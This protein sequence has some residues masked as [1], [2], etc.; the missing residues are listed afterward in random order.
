MLLAGNALASPRDSAWLANRPGLWRPHGLDDIKAQALALSRPGRLVLVTCTIGGD[1]LRR[2]AI[3][4]DLCPTEGRRCAAI[5]VCRSAF[6]PQNVTDNNL[7]FRYKLLALQSAVYA[8]EAVVPDVDV[9]WVDGN[10]VSWAGCAPYHDPLAGLHR[11]LQRVR[12]ASN[13]SIVFSSE[14]SPSECI[15]MNES[16]KGPQ[17]R[18]RCPVPKL[19]QWAAAL[20]PARLPPHIP[21][22]PI[23]LNS[24]VIAGRVRDLAPMLRWVQGRPWRWNGA[25]SDQ[26]LFYAWWLSHPVEVTLDYCSLLTHS[27]YRADHSL[28][29]RSADGTRLL[30]AAEDTCT[31][32]NQG[33]YGRCPESC[34]A[35]WWAKQPLLDQGP[36]EAISRARTTRASALGSIFCFAVT[37]LS[38][39]EWP[40]LPSFSR[41]LASCDESALY[42][43]VTLAV[44]VAIERAISGS[45]AVGRVGR[46]TWALNTPLF[47]QVWRHILSTGRHRGVQFTVKLDCDSIFWGARLRSVLAWYSG[48][49]RA[50]AATSP[51]AMLLTSFGPA[52]K[53]VQGGAYALS[54]AA[55]E[56]YARRRHECE[57]NSH[58]EAEDGYMSTCAGR[59]R[60]PVVAAPGLMVT[61]GGYPEHDMSKH[62]GQMF[63]CNGNGDGPAVIHPFKASHP[64]LR[65]A[66]L[67]MHAPQSGS[68]LEPA[69]SASY[70]RRCSSVL[71][72]W[73]RH[74]NASSAVLHA[75]C[76]LPP[77]GDT[78]T[79]GSHALVRVPMPKQSPNNR[80][81]ACIFPRQCCGCSRGP[82]RLKLDR[83][84]KAGMGDDTGCMR[85]PG[86][87]YSRGA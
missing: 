10:D 78:H 25:I 22:A 44:P 57:A 85:W 28:Y 65:R 81:T 49:Q 80:S 69:L 58:S 66:C 54:R 72:L 77:G 42:S 31:L 47:I 86:E 52:L 62:P 26:G 87:G 7:G 3:E 1:A 11:A 71:G 45:M 30:Y 60:L 4:R 55:L 63:L 36:E 38:R 12:E 9:L 82:W 20:C 84:L 29:R 70:L 2:S 27:M 41:M 18:W 75:D 21:A 24:G 46:S 19:P 48:A 40:L 73:C 32:H 5:N 67:R 83:H 17:R 53:H 74:A 15:T 79:H 64:E 43:N 76:E 59:L 37:T 23:Y 68:M 50:S 8:L 33:H 35:K 51:G 6:F 14:L 34:S 39:D 56:R 16:W 61:I 13:A